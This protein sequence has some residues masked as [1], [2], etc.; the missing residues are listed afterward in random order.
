VWVTGRVGD[1]LGSGRHLSFVPR[2]KEG[3]WLC[4]VLGAELRAMID[5]SD[6]VG[7][8]AGRIAA[9]SG[10][11]IEI[12][13]ESVPRHEGVEDALRAMGD[14]EDY[15]LVFVAG[16]GALK[17]SATG[18]GTKLTRI[19]R[20]VEGIAGSCVAVDARGGRVDVSQRGWDH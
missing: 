8:D 16:A 7:I 6:G 4:D 11:G 2:V 9:A 15:E 20:V 18:N 19:G 10:V 14:G 13:L 12:E 17:E 1:S 3:Q 5:V